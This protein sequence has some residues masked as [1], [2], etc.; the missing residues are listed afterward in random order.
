MYLW[1][2]TDREGYIKAMNDLLYKKYNYLK[3]EVTV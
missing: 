1:T 3:E 2:K